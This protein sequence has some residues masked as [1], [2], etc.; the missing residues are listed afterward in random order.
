MAKGATYTVHYRRRREQKTDY[1]K[2]LNLLKSGKTRFIVR[3]SNK[4]MVCQLVNYEDDGDKIVASAHSSELKEFGWTN[5]TSNVPAAYLTGM[6]CGLR[7]KKAGVADAILDMGL[8]PQTQGSRIYSSLKGLIDS[9]VESP[10]EEAIFPSAE[11]IS[12]KVIASYN[13]KAKDMEK[14]FAKSKEAILKST[15]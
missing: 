6:L 7:G 2:R 1:K 15:K 9:G 11:R 13:E 10:A 4:H 12:G 8:F 14:D 3:R 5:A